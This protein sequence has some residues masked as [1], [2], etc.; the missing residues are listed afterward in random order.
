MDLIAALL[1]YCVEIKDRPREHNDD[2]MST[3][4]TFVRPSCIE[5]HGVC[6]AIS[7]IV[8]TLSAEPSFGTKLGSSLKMQLPTKW[9][10]V[11]TAADFMVHVRTAHITALDAINRLR[12]SRLYTP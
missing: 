2:L 1:F 6:R 8:Q 5:Q 11:D 3:V 7:Y 9:G 10:P 4:L 12:N